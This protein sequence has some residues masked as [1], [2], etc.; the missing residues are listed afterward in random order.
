MTCTHPLADLELARGTDTDVVDCRRCGVRL[1]Q[2]D[3]RGNL[4]APVA[5]GMLLDDDWTDPRLEG[6]YL[7]SPHLRRAARL[8]GGFLLVV[9]GVT[10]MYEE[11]T[12]HPQPGPSFAIAMVLIVGA[13]W[14]ISR[15][16]D[17]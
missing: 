16:H 17:R 2:V 14:L 7:Q 3:S 4:R 10:L 8:I 15:K 1:A 11:G 5:P 6:H 9:I 13:G 12:R